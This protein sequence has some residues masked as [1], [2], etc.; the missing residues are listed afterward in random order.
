MIKLY[1]RKYKVILIWKVFN[2]RG[3]HLVHLNIN[4]VLS[5]I[6]ELRINAKN[7][8]AS[9]MGITESKLDKTVLDEEINIDGYEL[10]RSDRNRLGSG[11][12]CY[13]R[14]HSFNIRGDF[15]SKIENIFLDI[16]LPKPKHIVIGI[17][18]RPPDQSG[19]LDKLSQLPFPKQVVLIIRKCISLET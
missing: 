6:D 8:R 4:C 9:V 18:Y 12:V 11:V 1:P 5:K 2:K 14:N 17:L 3:L 10:A 7:S 15:S 16:F 13:I 19:F